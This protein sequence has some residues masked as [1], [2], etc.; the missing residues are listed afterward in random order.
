MAD[1]DNGDVE[2]TGSQKRNHD[3]QPV[4]ARGVCCRDCALHPPEPEC[5]PQ[6]DEVARGGGSFFWVPLSCC[7]CCVRRLTQRLGDP[8]GSVCPCA[9]DTPELELGGARG[10]SRNFFFGPFGRALGRKDIH[11]TA[12]IRC[13]SI[14][15]SRP[16]PFAAPHLF[17][18]SLARQRIS[19]APNQKK[20]SDMEALPAQ[21]NAR[22]AEILSSAEGANSGAA[23]SPPPPPPPIAETP[24][25]R[26]AADSKDNDPPV[27]TPSGTTRGQARGVHFDKSI[28]GAGSSSGSDVS[29]DEAEEEPGD[30]EDDEDDGKEDDGGE[31]E[32]DDEGE[33]D[34]DDGDE[35]EDDEKSPVPAAAP[36]RDPPAPAV[37]PAPAADGLRRSTRRREP[38]KR[39]VMDMT[40]DT[41]KKQY[42]EEVWDAGKQD[43]LFREACDDDEEYEEEIAE[44]KEIE[45]NEERN[46][47]FEF[48]RDPV[49]SGDEEMYDDL[50]ETASTAGDE[51]LPPLD[52]SAEHLA[53]ESAEIRDSTVDSKAEAE[54]LDE[55]AHDAEHRDI[56]ATYKRQREYNDDEDGGQ[57]DDDDDE[58]DEEEEKRRLKR[59]RKRAEAK[60]EAD[61][62]KRPTAAAPAATAPKK[63]QPEAAVPAKKKAD[64]D[65]D[66]DREEGEEEEDDDEF[67]DASQ[68][69][70][71]E[72]DDEGEEQ[73]GPR[74]SAPPLRKRQRTDAPPSPLPSP[75]ANDVR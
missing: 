47:D 1:D 52:D 34:D 4:G 41:K 75:A 5:F 74:A 64:N 50:D 11:K 55:E 21:G 69:D 71:E 70:D 19:T 10:E 37:E 29:S 24:A 67:V 58:D 14:S 63:Q 28:G 26:C 43:R 20:P 56:A 59:K 35:E 38:V 8:P 15:F 27:E 44:E 65:D 42:D 23:A 25:A 2:R 60:K 12:N 54:A 18:H 31:E 46:V 16:L 13:A 61:K 73:Q 22:S 7:R 49:A 17:A 45:E 30:E 9:F 68:D 32:E 36:A 3:G 62:A 53:L 66:D 33:H 39:L 40:K 72:D 48:T 57:D 51:K 6:V